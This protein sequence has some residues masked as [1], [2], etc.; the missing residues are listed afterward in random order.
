MDRTDELRTN[1][2]IET[3]TDEDRT[4]R[5]GDV[6][7]LGGSAVPKAPGDPV[8]EYDADSV[9]Q[10]RDRA[11]GDEVVRRPSDDQHGATGVDMG[12][13]GHGTDISRD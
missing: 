12:G 4:V 3:S 10:R 11:L 8:T 5:E 1:R 7:G 9:Q 6:L 2:E 13:G